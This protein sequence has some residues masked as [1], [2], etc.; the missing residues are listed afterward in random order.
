MSGDGIAFLSVLAEPR[1]GPGQ[2]G[3][4]SSTVPNTI[5]L[6]RAA[7]MP[8]LESY[9][10]KITVVLPIAPQL[11]QAPFPLSGNW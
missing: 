11:Q 2:N 6:G 3:R 9:C 1:A 10:I 7:R 4:K 5:F 8:S